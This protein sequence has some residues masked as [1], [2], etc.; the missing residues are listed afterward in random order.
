[1][2]IFCVPLLVAL[3]CSIGCNSQKQG[4]WVSIFDGKD[5]SGWTIKICGYPVGE[6][7]KN[8]FLVEDGMM[9]VDYSEYDRFDVEYAHIYYNR[10][11]SHYR[12]RLEYRFYGDRV[13]GSKKFTELNSGVMF[14][15]QSAES[16][17]LDQQF[18][19]SVE[20]QFLA[21]GEGEFS[22]RTTM[23]IATPGT[24]VVL[25]DGTLQRDHM[26]WTTAKARPRGEWVQVEIEVRGSELVI[27]RIDGEE[28]LRYRDPQIDD[29]FL[30]P[31]GYPLSAGTI[32]KDGYISLQG[33]SHPVD[34]RN[35]EL[36]ILPGNMEE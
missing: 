35:I 8:T 5:L 33:E 16:V 11:L 4:E 36:M 7:Y 17:G 12:L 14:H 2:R 19:V 28:V 13:K 30:L 25:E 26:T 10:K 32:L 18:P 1:M 23:N 15:S 29:N 24:S 3:L 31:E 20:A 34:F 22:D 6:N 21:Q 9:R 27:H